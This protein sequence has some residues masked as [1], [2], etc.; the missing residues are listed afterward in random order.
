M[1]RGALQDKVKWI[2][3]CK[4]GQDAELAKDFEL[5]RYYTH[6][7][8]TMVQDLSSPGVLLLNGSTADGCGQ[9]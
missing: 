9:V 5:C 2:S 7:M 8:P 1:L 3:D 4:G 6:W